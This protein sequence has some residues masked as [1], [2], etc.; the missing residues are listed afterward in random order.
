MKTILKFILILAVAA[1][2]VV[3]MMGTLGKSSEIRC[4][5]IELEIEDSMQN[6]LI[7]KTEL[8]EI[9]KK[10]KLSFKNKKTSEIN[11][12]HL[13]STFSQSPYIDT[14]S[15]KFNASGKLIL[16]VIPRK[17]CLHI[18]AKNGEDYYLDRNGMIMPTGN[19]RGNL[20]IVTGNVSKTLAKEKLTTLGR[21]IQDSAFWKTQV[22]QI[23]IVSNHDVRLYTRIADHV[24]HLGEPDSIPD[25]LHRLQ[26]FYQQGLPQTGWN[27]YESLSVEYQGL[28]I[29]T[30]KIKSKKN[31]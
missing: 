30:R 31:E 17:P 8:E 20:T 1:F 3:S 14:A 21:C 27:K 6:G 11:L 9:L 24:I 4:T 7:N 19:L 16:T 29:G 26:V 2:L 12:G 25:K 15:A 28:V 10:N 18:M 5:G 13:E 22:Q 23:D